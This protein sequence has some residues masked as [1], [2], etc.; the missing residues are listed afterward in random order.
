MD[1]IRR[2]LYK[3]KIILDGERSESTL[4][5]VDLNKNAFSD[6]Q[7][8]MIKDAGKG[9]KKMKSFSFTHSQTM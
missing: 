9:K 5:L 4:E 2:L 3:G 1:S 7:D 8:S 6:Y